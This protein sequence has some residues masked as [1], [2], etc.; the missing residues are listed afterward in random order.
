MYIVLTEETKLTAKSKKVIEVCKAGGYVRYFLE[1]QYTGVH[2]YVVRVYDH[3][4]CVVK[5]LG[6][7]SAHDAIALGYLKKNPFAR[8]NIMEWIF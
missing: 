5:G 1:R 8:N 6:Y 2:Q 3:N 4:C 7:K